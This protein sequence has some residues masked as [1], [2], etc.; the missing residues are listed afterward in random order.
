[1]SKKLI[2]IFTVTA[3]ALAD[4]AVQA[5]GSTA[6]RL[7]YPGAQ[8]TFVRG[9]HNNGNGAVVGFYSSGGPHG[10]LLRN[11]ERARNECPGHR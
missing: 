6:A 9:I 11:L 10:F 3:L 2:C 8:A 1:M 5:Q 4:P 7:D